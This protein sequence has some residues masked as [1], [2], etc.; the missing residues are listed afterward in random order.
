MII[1]KSI[2]NF[3]FYVD[4]YVLLFHLAYYFITTDPSTIFVQLTDV[5]SH[6]RIAVNMFINFIDET[7]GLPMGTIQPFGEGDNNLYTYDPLNDAN[8]PPPT[9]RDLLMYIVYIS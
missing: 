7:I 6:T 1:N 9:V 3:N 8:D 2:T 5:D 4:L